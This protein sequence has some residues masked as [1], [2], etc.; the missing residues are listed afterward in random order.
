MD[1]IRRDIY[2]LRDAIKF[3]I[4]YPQGADAID[5]EFTIRDY[6]VPAESTARIY[7]EKP[8]GKGVYNTTAISGN[9][10]TVDMEQQMTAEYGKASMQVEVLNGGDTLLSFVQ[11]LHV[12]KSLMKFDSSSGSNFVDEYL[13]MVQEALDKMEETR[14]EIIEAAERGDFTASIQVG[15]TSTLEP[16]LMAQ[17]QNVGTAMDAIFNFA[18]P[19]GKTGLTGP[20]G[21]QGIQGPVG[22]QGQPGKDGTNGIVTQVDPGLFAM[23]IS[24]E[25]NL[26]VVYNAADPAPPLQIVDGHLKYV[27]EDGDGS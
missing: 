9:V 27:I 18:I 14:E 12:K 4:N 1:K 26:I 20:T 23:Y 15:D 5:I 21:P 10:I 25:G 11:P 8:S 2:V 3:P 17:V 22:P 13:A 6:D 16:G 19:R 24:E 7:V